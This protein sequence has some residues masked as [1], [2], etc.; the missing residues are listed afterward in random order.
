MVDNLLAIFIEKLH[1]VQ[2]NSMYYVMLALISTG[3]KNQY[4]L[5]FGAQC[6][7]AY[8]AQIF[9][10]NFDV[11]RQFYDWTWVH[12]RM[13]AQFSKGWTKGLVVF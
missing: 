5:T 2:L 6:C 1:Q 8:K 3:V 9:A 13:T 7:R 10:N 11:V 4:A 12:Q